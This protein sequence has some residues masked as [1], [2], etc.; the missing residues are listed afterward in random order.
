M[1]ALGDRVYDLNA[2]C[3]SVSL[4]RVITYGPELNWSIIPCHMRLLPFAV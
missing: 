4:F 3:E 2:N 1:I